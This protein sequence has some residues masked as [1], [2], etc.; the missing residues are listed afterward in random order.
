MPTQACASPPT[1]PG[2][3]APAPERYPT[4]HHSAPLLTVPNHTLLPLRL[5]RQPPPQH[6]SCW[7]GRA[8]LPLLRPWCRRRCSRVGQALQ[9]QL[10]TQLLQL[11]RPLPHRVQLLRA[12]LAQLLAQLRPATCPPWHLAQLLAHRPRIRHPVCRAHRRPASPRHARPRPAAARAAHQ[13]Q[14][15]QLLLLP[16]LVPQHQVQ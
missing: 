5:R 14:P 9:P 8:L 1:A 15:L 11:A 7:I 3:C 16:P 4:L 12:H 13:R 2:S 10:A 6:S